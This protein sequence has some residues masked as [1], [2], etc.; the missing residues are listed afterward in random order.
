MP[1]DMNIVDIAARAKIGIPAPCYHDGRGDGCCQGCV[2]EIAGEESFACFTFPKNGMDVI[3]N[4][5][6]LK[7]LRKERIR[8]YQKT[9]KKE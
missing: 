9:N 8:A 6:D 5:A 4:R 1:C 2:V 7:S 3:V